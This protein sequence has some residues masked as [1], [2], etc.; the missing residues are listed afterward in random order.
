M[1]TALL[2]LIPFLAVAQFPKPGSSSGGGSSGSSGIST[3]TVSTLPVSPATNTVAQVTDGTTATDCATGMGSITH[4]CTWNGAAWI[5]TPSSIPSG[6]S[7]LTT[8]L[9]PK[10]TSSTS[11]GNS[12]ITDNG[13]TVNTAEPISA[14]SSAPAVTG[15]GVVGISENTGQ[16]CVAGAD[17][18]IGNATNHQALLSNNNVTA[19]PIAVTPASTTN[20]DV[21]GLSGTIGSVLT[22]TGKV[23]ANLVSTTDTTRSGTASNCTSSASPA[24]CVAAQAGS[25]AIPTGI[26]SVAL[27]VNTTAVTANSQIFVFSDDSLGTKLSVTCNSTLAT[28]V[29]GLA[30]TART[31]ATSF[32]VTYNGTIA[33]NPLCVS[34]LVVN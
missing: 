29:G 7:G 18:I 30:I 19:V 14:G 5:G 11:I 3:Y 22:D 8:N 16:G 20:G 9:I 24:V 2:I 1:R 21:A 31:A 12:S 32:T 17:C 4:L 15:T 33:T 6:I 25:V 23:A 28:L 27:T 34:F 26:T 13:T 10:A